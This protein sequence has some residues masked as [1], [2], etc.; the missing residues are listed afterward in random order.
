MKKKVLSFLVVFLFV[1]PFFVL[2]GCNQGAPTVSEPI[3][4]KVEFLEKN[5]DLFLGESKALDYSII[6]EDAS[7]SQIL[8]QSSNPDVVAVDGIVI[9]A[10]SE[11]ASV[12]TASYES[13]ILGQC[14]VKAKHIEP[15]RIWLNEERFEGKIG[16]IIDIPLYSYPSKITDAL[17]TVKIADENVAIYKE[18]LFWGVGTGETS[19]SIIH[20]TTGL[21]VDCIIS[22][23]AV[24]AESI[25]IKCSDSL[26]IADSIALEAIFSPED[27]TDQSIIWQSSDEKIAS[28][29]NSILH[30]HHVG[31][32]TITALS[33]SGMMVEKEIEIL[34]I[35]PEDLSLVCEKGDMLTVGD[36]ALITANITPE[37]TTDKTII[38][39]TSDKSKAIVNNDGLVKAIAPGVVQIIAEL[40]NGIKNTISFTINPRPVSISNGFIKRPAGN[41]EAP[42]TVHASQTESCYVYFKHDS[43]SKYD[44]S[45]FVSAGSTTDVKAPVGSYTMY[46]ASGKTW[47]GTDYRF[48]VGTNYYKADSTFR[49]YISG[50]YVYGTEVTL[51][52]VIGGNMDSEQISENEFPG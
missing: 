26:Y 52:Q 25:S 43:N 34:P 6:P 32:V 19:A 13:E 29:D 47:Y 10:I 51:Y 9:T 23:T 24:E 49:F 50:N 42:V 27:T 17:Y 18:G 5:I 14:V 33:S 35:L 2:I 46:Y 7:T 38:W 39:S 8:L 3:P 12:I 15:E 45:L 30:A 4:L 31:V 48:G 40:S 11:G 20:K 41:C 21:A 44:F 1:F 36:S 22:V 28:I 16:R 37:N